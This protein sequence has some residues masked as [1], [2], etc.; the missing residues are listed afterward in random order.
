MKSRVADVFMN[1]ASPGIIA[2]AMLNAYYD[3]YEDYLTAIA[4][5]MRK[6]YT[7]VVDAGFILQLDASDLAI[8][9]TMLLS[10]T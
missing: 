10:N 3:T 7:A 6:E 1:A 4:R 5:E 8:E 2:T 9:R